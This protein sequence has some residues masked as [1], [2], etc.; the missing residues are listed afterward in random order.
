VKTTDILFVRHPET[1]ANIE[2]RLN[3][4]MSSPLTATGRLQ[5]RRVPRKICAFKPDR[6]LTSPLERTLVLAERAARLC[7]CPL[8]IDER[9]IELD[10][11]DAEGLTFEEIA[12][13]GFTFNFRSVDDPVAPGG[14]SRADIGR[15]SA[16]VCDELTEAGGR[17]VV[18]T[19]GGVFRSS[20]VHLLGLGSE[21][22][23]S[24]HIHNAQLAHVRV[25]EGHGSLEEYVQG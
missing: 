19:H 23:W 3:G 13:A 18:V 22:I 7:G 20:L 14:E 21:A 2:G 16:E 24:F 9:I 15:R 25:I 10:F 6:I 17:Y 1:T 12:E 11:G 8:E 5:L 4:R